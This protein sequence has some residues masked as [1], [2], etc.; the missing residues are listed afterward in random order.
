MKL[1][2]PFSV[3]CREATYLLSLKEEGKLGRYQTFRLFT[4]M[5]WCKM[6]QEFEKQN[7]L[8]INNLNKINSDS[9]LPENFKLT[10]DLKI[11]EE[12]GLD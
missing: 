4:H 6:C 10:L 3:P 12:L 7:K 9:V 2:N 5:I 11:K 1:E 8:I